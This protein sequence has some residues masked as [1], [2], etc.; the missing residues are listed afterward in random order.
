MR[1]PLGEGRA[2]LGGGWPAEPSAPGHAF[3]PPAE[4]GAARGAPGRAL[5]GRS[6]TKRS[7]G[8]LAATAH[9]QGVGCPPP[10]S[11]HGGMPP[12]PPIAPIPPGFRSWLVSVLRSACAERLSLRPRKVLLEI[13]GWGGVVVCVKRSCK[14][15]GVGSSSQGLPF[16]AEPPSCLAGPRT[17][18]TDWGSFGS[19]RKPWGASLRARPTK[20]RSLCGK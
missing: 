18:R 9:H 17:S 1:R 7:L 12:R 13:A 11:S 16:D 5:L 10:A 2:A 4:Q 19:G 8:S 14:G 6:R 3:L 20:G 15:C